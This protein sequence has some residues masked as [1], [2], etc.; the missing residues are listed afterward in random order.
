M[1][2][3]LKIHI[4]SM[5][6]LLTA[7]SCSDSYFDRY[8]SDQLTEGTFFQGPENVKMM[9]NDAYTTLRS[10]YQYIYYVGDL[11]SDDS[12]NSKFNNSS[13]HITIN[14]SNVTAANSALDF[15]WANSYNTI[16]RCN[17]ALEQIEKITIDETVKQNY[18]NEAKFI[19]ALTYFNMVRIF[20][21]VPLVL[22]DVK[23]S[24]EAFSYGRE[25]LENVYAQIVDD[26]ASAKSLPSSYTRNEDK[27]RATQWAA[28]ALLAKVQLTRRN[29]Q[30]A[31]TELEDVINHSPHKLLDTYADIFEADNPNNDEIIFA[32]QYA[33]GFDPD[34]GNPIVTGCFPNEEVG[35]NFYSG[36]LSRGTGVFLMTEELYALYTEQDAR[37]SM[38]HV[39]L[40]LGSQRYR[41]IFTM[42]YF[43]KSMTTKVDSGCDWIVLR[44]A[45]I[46]LM[47]AEVMN[48]L[49][50]VATAAACVDKIRTRAKLDTSVPVAADQAGMR[51]AV[52][53]ERRLELFCE[54]HR[55]FDLVR[56]GRAIEVMNA[57]FKSDATNDEIGMNCSVEEYELVF[58]IPR[59]QVTLNPDKIK[60]NPRY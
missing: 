35:G 9:L 20:G 32:I 60:Q 30:A 59:N 18:R 45:D 41:Y 21:D 4:I 58:P 14:E 19:R 22:K 36:I 49:G 27:G 2:S 5:A 16:A 47:Y 53:K 33:R 8:P 11:P 26:L 52:E 6:C 39:M 7:V 50:D 54:C 29:F 57:H 56:T 55:W 51:L 1:K 34:M 12:Y 37:K 25:P 44:F 42:K 13:D 23:T 38:M 48:E 15:L 28:K 31:K 24:E 3:Q 46:L 43:D 10:V 40:G 17:M